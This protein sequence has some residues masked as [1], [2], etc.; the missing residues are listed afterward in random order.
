M[1]TNQDQGVDV[2]DYT[3]GADIT[4]GSPVVLGATAGGMVTVGIALTDIANGAT[5]AVAIRGTF[6][7]AKVSAAVITQGE[8]VNWDTSESGVEDNA[9][10]AATGDVEDFGIAMESA[11]NGVT[12]VAVQLLPGHGTLSA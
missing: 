11:G 7:M 8:T 9:H 12:T 1:A 4:S 5:G 10:T 6:N 3:A 2:V